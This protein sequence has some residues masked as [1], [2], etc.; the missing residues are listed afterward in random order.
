MSSTPP[1]PSITIQELDKVDIRV[2][3]ITMVEVP[4]FDKLVRLTVDFAG[5]E[6]KS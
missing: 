5:F 2:G 3:K 4:K 6:R 1:K